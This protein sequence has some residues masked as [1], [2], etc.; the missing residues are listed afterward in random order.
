MAGLSVAECTF[1]GT[2]IKDDDSVGAQVLLDAIS[3]IDESFGDGDGATFSVEA[4]AIFCKASGSE[5][6]ANSAL[7]SIS[8]SA[9]NV[10]TI[11]DT[12]AIA[13]VRALQLAGVAKTASV[14]DA[15]E[16]SLLADKV[17][18]TNT[19]QTTA[20]ASDPNSLVASVWC[21]ITG[22]RQKQVV[23]QPTALILHNAASKAGIKDS[24]GLATAA[25]IQCSTAGP[26]CTVDIDQSVS[27]SGHG[28]IAEGR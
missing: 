4:S 26:T 14:G 2:K 8:N 24:N 7:C 10:F 12:S 25:T 22:G 9:G 20:D 15:T 13:L 17:A 21:D 27:G 1:N 5:K 11:S 6:I 18:C 28:S 16:Y 19:A 3:A 23:D